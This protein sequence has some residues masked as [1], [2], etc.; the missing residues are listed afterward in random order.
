MSLLSCP[1]VSVNSGD[2]KSL[3]DFNNSEKVNAGVACFK[4]CEMSFLW[5][6]LFLKN[7]FL[8]WIW[9]LLSV[10]ADVISF[11]VSNDLFGCLGD[12]SKDFDWGTGLG[13][14]EV[15]L[16]ESS[17]CDTMIGKSSSLPVRWFNTLV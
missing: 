8:W 5:A 6:S 16:V 13:N 10:F 7:P 3:G 9:L 1:S 2:F 12:T 17:K 14:D 4:A 15:S 11:E